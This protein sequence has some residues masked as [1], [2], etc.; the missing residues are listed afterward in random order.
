MF[1]SKLM[2][3]EL[4]KERT[5]RIRE[6]LVPLVFLLAIV[7][8]WAMVIYVAATDMKYRSSPKTFVADA[9]EHNENIYIRVPPS[10]NEWIWSRCQVGSSLVK[11]GK[12]TVY[13]IEDKGTWY[14][15][16]DQD[17]LMCVYA[18]GI[19]M[20]VLIVYWNVKVIFRKKH[21]VRKENAQSS[22]DN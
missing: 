7:V 8:F 5:E 20:T 16:L 11:N 17:M 6:I 21:A 18:I 22:K 13:Y 4:R 14:I 9:I 2:D 15:P 12:V 10:R 3:D 19:L 1:M